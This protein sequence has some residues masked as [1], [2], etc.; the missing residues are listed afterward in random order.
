MKQHLFCFGE[1]YIMFKNWKIDKD[2][3]RY[4][5]K[6]RVGLSIN[7]LNRYKKQ[8]TITKKIEQTNN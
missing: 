7:V 3:K 5:W 1:L 8:L 4:L 6:E 2:K